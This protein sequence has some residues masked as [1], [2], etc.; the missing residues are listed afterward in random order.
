[1]RLPSPDDS[2]R[3]A[4]RAA[5]IRVRLARLWHGR[6][7]SLKAASFAL[8]GVINTAVDYGVFLLARAAYQHLPTALW[9]FGAAA[10]DCR[11]GSPRTMLLVAANVTSWTVAVSGSYIMNSSITF[12][13]ESGRQLR[14]SRYLIFILVG[15]AGLFANTAA[16]LFAAETLALPIYI[17]KALAILVSFL[18]NFSLSHFVVFRVRR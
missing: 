1:M 2:A 3:N 11:C 7:I 10:A 5:A 8:V 17:A 18:V 15:V 4:G 6:A 16:L 9:L 12:A 13:A 14:W